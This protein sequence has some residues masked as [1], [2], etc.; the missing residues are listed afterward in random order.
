MDSSPSFPTPPPEAL[1]DL[2]LACRYGEPESDLLEVQEFVEKYGK[3]ALLLAV[4]ARGNTV[5]HMSGGN[6]HEGA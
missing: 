1:E 2:L 3:E 4:D 6:G 5:L